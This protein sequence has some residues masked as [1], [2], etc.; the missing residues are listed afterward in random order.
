M[1]FHQLPVG[2]R[3]RL[4]NELY[5]KT[6]PLVASHLESD[7][8]RLIRRSA[9]VMPEDMGESA[10]P[11]TI[12]DLGTRRVMTAALTTYHNHCSMSRQPATTEAGYSA[13]T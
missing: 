3:F 7:R 12:Q 9:L 8:E 11:P 13:S 5:I 6:S 10:A 2:A 4:D 1:K